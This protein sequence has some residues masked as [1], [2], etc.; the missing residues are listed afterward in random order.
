MLSFLSYSAFISLFFS[1]LA[2]GADSFPIGYCIAVAVPQM[3]GCVTPHGV[4]CRL[5]A[6]MI[7]ICSFHL[8][9]Y[10]ALQFN[11]SICFAF[12]AV[13]RFLWLSKSQQS[14]WP[15]YDACHA[16]K[17]PRCSN[18]PPSYGGMQC[19]KMR[20]RQAAYS[21]ECGP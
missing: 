18:S 5:P 2:N 10:F 21:A 6:H 14:K 17:C 19:N 16:P 15:R 9:L 8:L 12:N 3:T 13:I 7:S 20:R 11:K 4:P 1:C